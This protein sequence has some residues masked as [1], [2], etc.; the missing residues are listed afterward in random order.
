MHVNKVSEPDVICFNEMLSTFGLSQLI[1]HPTHVSGNT[2]DLLIINKDD[3]QI[4]DIVIDEFNYSDHSYIFFNIPYA[5]QKSKDKVISIKTYKDIDLDEFKNDIVAK[6]NI[7]TQKSHVKFSEAL[8]DYNVLCEKEV[9]LVTQ[10]FCA[11]CFSCV[12]A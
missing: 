1:D 11:S 10:K 12:A 7:F 8:D 3:T 5:F 6:I 4:K 2:L 9:I